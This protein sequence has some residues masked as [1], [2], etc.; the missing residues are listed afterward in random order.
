MIEVGWLVTGGLVSGRI[1]GVMLTLPVLGMTGIPGPA[2]ALM[3]L[4]LTVIIAPAV[5]QVVEPPT[6]AALTVGL[7]GEVVIGVLMGGLVRF[8]F[9]AL[10][11]GGELIGSQT[12][13]AAALQF[14]PTLQLSQGPLGTM[15]VFLASAVFVGADLHLQFLVAL[16]D[17]F[18]VI[19]PGARVDLLAGAVMW[20]D[21]AGAVIELGARLAAP[22]VVLVFLI[23]LFVAV[24]TRLA[25]QMNIFFS[26]GMLLTLGA[27]LLIYFSA[28]PLML[29]TH[30]GAVR[31]TMALLPDLL[32]RMVGR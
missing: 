32:G 16:A 18:Y 19:P 21:L 6:I 9:G 30:L 10:S 13:H 24:I 7:L 20:V 5:P 1:A 22:V 28:L 17:S 8:M 23:N 31:D 29:D 14:D 25:P 27:G 2:R 12:G 11:L 15:V 26:V 4:A 3:S